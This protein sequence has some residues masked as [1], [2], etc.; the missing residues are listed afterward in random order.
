MIDKPKYY[1]GP[2]EGKTAAPLFH[3]IASYLT[4]KYNIPLSKEQSP[5]V[6]LI[7]P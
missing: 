5:V 1:G 3:E 2:P 6:P 7:Q 4:Q